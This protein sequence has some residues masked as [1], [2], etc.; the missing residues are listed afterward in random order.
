VKFLDSVDIVTD[1]PE[2]AD[3]PYTL[4]LPDGA[5]RK[6]KLDAQ[7]KATEVNLPPGPCELEIGESEA[8]AGDDAPDETADDEEA[9]NAAHI[10]RL[11]GM[12]FDANKCFLL[13]YALPGIKAIVAMHKKFGDAKVLIVGHDG[14]DEEMKSVHLAYCRAEILGAYLTNDVEAW[15]KWFA[16]NNPVKIRWGTRE[17]Q[18]MLSSLPQGEKPFFIGNA[19]GITDKK[20]QE[21][22]KKFQQ[23][24]NDKLGGKLKVDG[25]AGPK[26]I[27]EL[28]K[29]YMGIED[30]TLAQHIKPLAHG[31][32]G[33]FE[34]DLTAEGMQPDERIIEVFFFEKGI[35]PTPSAKTSVTGDTDYFAWKKKVIETENHEFHGIHLQIV[36]SKK[37]P[38]K[39]AKAFLEG[40]KKV[41]GMTDEQGFAFFSGLVAGQYTVR[42]EKQGH[43]INTTTLTYPTA[44]TLS[45]KTSSSK[46]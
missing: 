33:Q 1:P 18:L 24:C 38:V 45:R 16:T 25:V 20:T 43:E 12:T 36:D 35:R 10:V 2:K 14:G 17:V 37:K 21:A 28:L 7:G 31:C 11:I 15:L 44:K 29:A 23:Y 3:T 5:S 4:T 41:E 6:G 27:K 22:A 8:D 42:A 13:P 30:T 34:D 19:S 46:K 40:P 9:D 39:F 26:T 32:E